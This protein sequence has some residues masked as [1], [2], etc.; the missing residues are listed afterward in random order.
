[1]NVEAGLDG[2]AK[3]ETKL[4]SYH[5]TPFDKI[6][7]GMTENDVTN[8]IRVNYIATTLYSVIADGSYHE[9]NLGREA[10][11]SLINDTKLQPNCSQ[12]GFNNQCRGK[13]RKLRIGLVTSNRNDCSWCEAVIGFGIKIDSLGLSSGYWHK[14]DTS[15]NKKFTFGYIF[16]Q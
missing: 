5:N 2:L 6:C 13:K 7:L 16:V 12:A 9:I 8:W 14:S 11:K 4:A 1:M 3:N 10:W 15:E